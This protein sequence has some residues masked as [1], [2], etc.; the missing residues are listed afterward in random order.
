MD[1]Y[2][3]NYSESQQAKTY[4]YPLILQRILSLKSTIIIKD[5]QET[6]LWV[7]LASVIFTIYLPLTSG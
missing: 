5:L 6:G 1:H 4:G 3:K 7:H 2:G